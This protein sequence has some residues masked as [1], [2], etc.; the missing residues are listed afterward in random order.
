[1]AESFSIGDRVRIADAD[2]VD[3]DMVGKTGTVDSISPSGRRYNILLDERRHPD[4]PVVTG[5][6]AEELDAL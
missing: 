5:Y 1:M 4:V 6:F 3:R 2:S